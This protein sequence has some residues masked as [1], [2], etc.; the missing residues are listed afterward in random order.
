MAEE[1]EGLDLTDARFWGVDLSSARFRDVNMTGVTV[2]HARFVDVDIDGL[3]D[4]VV[5]NGVEVTQFVNERDRWHPLRA[6]LRPED[7]DGL[8]QSWDALGQAWAPIVER[9]RQLSN[10]QV[11]ESVSSEWSL[12][13]TF[14]HLVFAV[15]KW[16]TVPVL[17]GIFHPAGLPNTG[18][19]DFGWPGIDREAAPTLEEV[20][21]VRVDRA[22]QMRSY[23]DGVVP[24]D[25]TRKVD[26]LENGPNPVME[27]LYTVFEEEFEHN[28]YA[29]RDLEYFS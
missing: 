27:C 17:G 20:L 29:V 9:S 19:L 8:R 26:V 7:P 6:M 11:H 14:R 1:F 12:V 25:L 2:S 22:A 21:A 18:S 23:L 28:R 4:R 24:A 10:A 13:E 5:I 16:F 3:V 15:D